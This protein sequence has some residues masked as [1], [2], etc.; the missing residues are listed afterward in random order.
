MTDRPPESK[1]SFNAVISFGNILTIIFILGT[2]F[3]TTA[4]I[5]HSIDQISERVTVLETR[6]TNLDRAFYEHGDGKHDYR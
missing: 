1:V 5:V 2:A 6:V 3:A 4:E